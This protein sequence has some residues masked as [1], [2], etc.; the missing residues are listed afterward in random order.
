MRT[1]AYPIY[2]VLLLFCFA[3]GPSWAETTLFDTTYEGKLAGL[4]IETRR[5]LTRLDDGTYLLKSKASNFMGSLS[6]ISHFASDGADWRPVKYSYQRR[7]F[8]AKTTETI[9]FD[10]QGLTAFYTH[11]S[12]PE[13]DAQLRLTSGVLDPAL[14]Q[15][16]L[17]RDLV[18]GFEKLDYR[19]AKRDRI[20][21]YLIEPAAIEDL[22]IRDKTYSAIKV[23]RVN[24]DDDKQTYVWVIPDLYYLLGKIVHVEDDGD[25][26]QMILTRHTINRVPLQALFTGVQTA[27]Q[28]HDNTIK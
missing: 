21:H 9:D 17:Q 26:H 8:G 2:Q 13:R 25:A 28:E 18:L 19:F 3:S 11:S 24:S 16:R 20:R 7:I 14:Y 23:E 1:F 5:T 4:T 22:R 15:L 27:P 6:E 12:K 10:W